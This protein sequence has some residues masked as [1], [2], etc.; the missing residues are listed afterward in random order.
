MRVSYSS[1]IARSEWNWLMRVSLVLLT[2]AMLPGVLVAL[3]TAG[4]SDVQYMGAV[5]Q[6]NLAAA[7]MGRLMQGS[8]GIWLTEFMHTPE[9]HAGIF[10]QPIYSLLGQIAA[11]TGI[12]GVVMFHSG[13][14]LASLFMYAALYH[15]GATIWVRVRSRQIFFLLSALGMGVGV[16]WSLLNNDVLTPD[17]ILPSA[18][19]FYASL[20]NI[21]YPLGI[22]CVALIVSVFVTVLRPGFEEMPAVQNGGAAL[23]FAVI[24]LALLH[25]AA[26]LPAISAFAICV[27][28]DWVSRRRLLIYQSRWLL[29]AIVPALPVGA[30]LVAVV[31]GNS[32]VP[33]WLAQPLT[34]RFTI[35]ELLSGAIVLL[36]MGLPAWWRAIRAFQRDGDRLFL[37]WIVFIVAFWLSPVAFSPM[38]LLGM[39]VPLAYFATRALEEVWLPRIN[40]RLQRRAYVVGIIFMALS[41]LLLAFIPVLPI[42]AGGTSSQ[43]MLATDYPRALT[44]IDDQTSEIAVVLAAPDVS[45][46]IPTLADLRTYYG[47]PTETMFASA[48]RAFVGEWY[49][50][51]DAAF[52]RQ[53][54]QQE[55]TPVGSYR[56]DYVLFGPSERTLGAGACLENWQLVNTIGAVSVYGCDADCRAQAN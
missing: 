19:P 23:A 42:L 52:C 45:L 37:L 10:L 36:L 5:H 20:T 15:L 49:A 41:P 47:H 44:W 18:Y 50:S 9:A 3:V 31:G 7:D 55:T 26:L 40:R 8:R 34:G 30:Y 24:G 43:M 33:F 12:S 13:R 27:L 32:A 48:R 39:T 4:R 54:Q 14:L 29:W 53:A 11:F 2:L 56:I 21:Q 17:L 22:G 25:P 28:I 1:Y 51:T 16:Y 38:F 46:W 6:V 35:P